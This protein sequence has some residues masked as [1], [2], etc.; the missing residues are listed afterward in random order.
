MA[1]LP[2]LQALGPLL[3]Q[4]RPPPPGQPSLSP[5]GGAVTP[6]MRAILVDWMFEAANEFNLPTPVL[7]TAVSLLDGCLAAWGWRLPQGEL[8]LLAGVC[9][10][11]ESRRGGNA[12][13]HAGC[14]TVAGVVFIADG[15]YDGPQVVRMVRRALAAAATAEEEALLRA[16]PEGSE[17]WGDGEGEALLGALPGLLGAATAATTTVHAFLSE[18]LALGTQPCPPPTFGSSAA[19]AAAAPALPPAPG[20]VDETAVLAHFLCDLSLLDDHIDRCFRPATVAAAALCLARCTARTSL[21]GKPRCTEGRLPHGGRGRPFIVAPKEEAEPCFGLP[22]LR[23]FVRSARAEASAVAAC[24]FRLWA[25]LKVSNGV[26]GAR[27]RVCVCVCVCR[28]RPI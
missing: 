23:A 8:Q 6:H 2:H 13:T 17:D 22:S 7:H 16:V 18:Y 4:Q 28:S 14:M 9:L 1:A 20:A 15:L 26:V 5:E 11:I 25:L 12:H 27:A 24:A 3:T 19:A 21:A 10:L